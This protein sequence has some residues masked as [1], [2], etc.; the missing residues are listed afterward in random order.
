MAD[1]KFDVLGIGNAIVDVLSHSDDAFLQRHGMP[2]GT[3]SLIDDAAAEAI[4][5]D[6]GPGIEASGGSAA[7][8]IAG[9]AAMGGN[10]DKAQLLG[11]LGSNSQ[12]SIADQLRLLAVYSLSPSAADG[13]AKSAT[14]R[15]SLAFGA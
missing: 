6:M 1:P 12:G 9:L 7:N 13:S 10:A 14:Q 11:L 8:T 5:A 3:M 15:S 2:K 4:Y